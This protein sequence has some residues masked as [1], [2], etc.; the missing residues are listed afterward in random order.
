MKRRE[1]FLAVTLL[2]ALAK[3]AIPKD[4]VTWPPPGGTIDAPLPFSVP[5]VA[6]HAS[7]CASA[8]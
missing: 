2:G 8:S 7:Q 3:P 4:M 6:R 1:P 5:A